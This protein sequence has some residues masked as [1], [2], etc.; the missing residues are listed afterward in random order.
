MVNDPE[1][2][3]LVTARTWLRLLH[4]AGFAGFTWPAE[5]GGRGLDG[6]ETVDG[7]A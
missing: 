7:G 5:D 3:R 1:D 2:A 4:E 6:R